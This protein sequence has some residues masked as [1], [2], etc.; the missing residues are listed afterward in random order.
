MFGI[1]SA[2]ALGT[3]AKPPAHYRVYRIEREPRHW[4][5]AVEARGYREDSGTFQPEPRRS[6]VFEQPLFA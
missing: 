1:P 6:L 4:R 3:P 5:V 2:S